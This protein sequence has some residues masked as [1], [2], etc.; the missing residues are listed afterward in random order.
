MELTCSLVDKQSKLGAIPVGVVEK[1]W[2]VIFRIIGEDFFLQSY[3][4]S[5]GGSQADFSSIF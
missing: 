5:T 1:I 3:L 2:V 4:A